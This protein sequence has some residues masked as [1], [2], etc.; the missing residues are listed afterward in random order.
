MAGHS[1]V[2]PG[3]EYCGAIFSRPAGAD[4]FLQI[5]MHN[6][7]TLLKTRWLRFIG[8]GFFDWWS[9]P[10]TDGVKS[11]LT[12]VHVVSIFELDSLDSLQRA[13]YP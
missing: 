9:Q 12:R 4:F 5:S 13:L 11:R 8:A 1:F 7:L 10:L 6:T 2:G 3:G